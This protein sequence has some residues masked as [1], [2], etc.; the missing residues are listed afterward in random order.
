MTTTG[1]APELARALRRRDIPGVY[2]QL[3][4]LSEKERKA[5]F[6]AVSAYA[7][8]ELADWS[9]DSAAVCGLALLGCAPSA[10]RA[11]TALN[12]GSLR[13][14]RQSI[15]LTEVVSLLVKREVPW[16]SELVTLW[17]NRTL[18]PREWMI[19]DA[20]ITAAGLEPPLTEGFAEGWF[21]WV[22]RRWKTYEGLTAGPYAPRLLPLLF[23]YERIGHVLQF[24]DGLRFGDALLRLADDDRSVRDLLL[25]GC[26][27]RLL[28]GGRAADLR[29][30]V[31]LHDRLAPSREEVAARTHDY[32]G[33]LGSDLSTAAAMAQKALRSADEGGLLDVET[34]LDVSAVALQRTEKG[35]LKTQ[36]TWVRQAAGRHP[37][38][39]ADLLALLEV[40][41]ET[42]LAA[43]VPLPGP[44]VPEMP[45][46]I[47]T[48]TELA[49]E[50]AALLAGDRS[51]AT[52][53]RVLAGLV[54]FHGRD[55]DA[56]AA[57]ITPVVTANEDGLTGTW[58][59]EPRAG[60]GAM[61][62]ALLDRPLSTTARLMEAFRD[63]GA[64]HGLTKPLAKS[65]RS[66]ET[67]LQVRMA[68]I[69]RYCRYSPVPSLVATPTR[70]NGHIDP[71][72]LVARLERVEREGWEPW[73][74]DLAQ[75]LL[76]LP[77]ED[78]G[79]DLLRRAA[80]LHSAAG[81]ALTQ[82]LRDGQPDP[83]VTR[84]EQRSARK[85]ENYYYSW[86]LPEWRLTAALAPPPGA[87]TLESAMFHLPAHDKPV[88][89]P[90]VAE[91]Q[92][93]AAALPSHREVVAAWALP[94]LAAAAEEAGG[95][96][97][98]EL[99]PL[100]A[101]G[102]GPAGPATSLALVYGM[103]ARDTA[104][105]VAALDAIIGFGDAPE[106]RQ[107]GVDLGDCV[108][109]G[110]LTLSRAASTLRDAAEAGAADAVGQ[111][112][113][114]ALPALLAMEKPR[115][116]TADVLAVAARCVRATGRR[117]PVDGLAEIA[118]R[119]ASS[120][121]VAAARDLHAALM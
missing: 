13:W 8:E 5:A 56:L 52:V 110:G 86:R 34:L 68:A 117:Q 71:A 115:P 100:L 2:A 10:K 97:P 33:L 78:P 70:T 7:K 59:R 96:G 40:T 95:R 81:K 38:R 11:M 83:V 87:G 112:C 24:G 88:H 1:L 30:Y 19:L 14:S 89:G 29:P 20:L 53:E 15:P 60:L 37:Q 65:S 104:D 27:A 18:H 93:W 109:S 66:P 92:T 22:D 32:L 28:R 55:R 119:K 21:T 54:A 116:G 39:A 4:A 94:Q 9:S 98:A 44:V 77:R 120:Q 102:H 3:L 46:P 99:L 74:L 80:A 67:I 62:F 31:T 69:T 50:L 64:E 58:A 41:A 90:W 72:V 47:A 111:I 48:P 36:S 107:T 101:D 103:T 75:A 49:E 61:L 85:V 17:S 23:E 63:L 82:R 43:P 51:V 12:R 113:L 35:F 42:P 114:G 84:V 105:R 106:W 6:P 73:H 91:P 76:R 121:L 79:G 45:P 108:A 26:L 16:L 25:T 118:A 57:A